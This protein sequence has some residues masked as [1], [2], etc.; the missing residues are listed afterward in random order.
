MHEDI[1]VIVARI[2][3]LN[4]P[5][6]VPESASLFTDL[7]MSSIDYVDLCC[8]IKEQVDDCVSLD[9]LWPFNRML[10]DPHFH[11]GSEWTES[12][13]KRVCQ[14]M[15][16]DEKHGKCSLQELYNHFSVNFIVHRIEQLSN[17]GMK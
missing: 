6:Q 11:T 9:N 10:L 12:G 13:W 4:G 8:E 14:V 15:G 17:V 7:N 16:W 1:K 5:E 3:Y 2:L